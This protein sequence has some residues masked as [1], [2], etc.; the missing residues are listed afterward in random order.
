MSVWEVCALL[1]T[2]VR[3]NRPLRGFMPY[4]PVEMDKGKDK[5]G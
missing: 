5:R 1:A 3:K 4:Q 2:T